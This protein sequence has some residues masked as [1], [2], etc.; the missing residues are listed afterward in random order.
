MP[1]AFIRFKI[2]ISSIAILSSEDGIP[3]F[4]SKAF[5]AS[6][7]AKSDVPPM[8]TPTIIG[9]HGLPPAAI[10]VSK[11]NF[12]T[13]STPSPGNAIFKA[14]LFSEPKPFGR[15]VSSIFTS[16][17]RS[18]FTWGIFLPVFVPVFSR[19][20]GSTTLGRRGISL[21]ACSTPFFMPS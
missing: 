16:S 13:P 2:S 6:F 9:G 4:L 10:T 20:R 14:L 18:I 12:L 11:T 17:I 5:L 21:V 7:M 15:T 1:V 3:I 8:P 19:V